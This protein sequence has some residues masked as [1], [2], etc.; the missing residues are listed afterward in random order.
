M[1]LALVLYFANHGFKLSIK[2]RKY[3]KL[4]PEAPG[5]LSHAME[6]AQVTEEGA[7]QITAAEPEGLRSKFLSWC[8]TRAPAT[9]PSSL[10]VA[11]CLQERGSS[12]ATQAH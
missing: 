6:Q 8:E 11:S 2:T 5:Y 10:I 12:P 4:T 1:G 7:G 9:I 3:S